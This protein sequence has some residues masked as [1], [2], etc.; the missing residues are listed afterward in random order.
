MPSEKQHFD[1]FG[2]NAILIYISF[3]KFILLLLFAGHYGLFRDEYYY[4]ECSK[5]LSWG[6][7]DQPPLSILILAFSRM[8]FGDSILGIRLFAYIASCIAI[9]MSGLIARQLGGGRFAQVLTSLSM[10]FCAVVLG[11]GSYFSMNAFDV[12]FGSIIF[13]LL[14]KL[15][16]YDNPKTWITLGL[17]FGIGLEN[18]F[19]PLFLAFGLV[20][21][22]FLTKQRKYFLTKELYIGAAIAFLIFLP[23]VI[24]Q[25]ANNF[26]TLEFIRNASLLKNVPLGFLG[27]LLGSLLELNPLYVLY[28]VIALIFLLFNK[29]GKKF[30]LVAWTYISVFVVFVLN[31]G[32]PYYMG[33]LYPVIIASGIVGLDILIAENGL[34]WFR[35]LMI[36]ILVASAVLVTPFSIPVLKVDSFIRY[37]ESL[38]LK[39]GNGERSSLGILPQFYADRFG[40]KEM[41]EK[42]SVVYNKLSDDEKKKVLIFAQNY[43]EA[44]AV[45]YYRNEFELPRAVSRHNSFWFWGYPKDFNGDIM[46]VIGSNLKD[47]SMFFEK[48]ELTAS[49]SS[50]YGM[51]YE[52]VDIFICRNLKMP[53]SELWSK[54][55]LFI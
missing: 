1:L 30:A 16:K 3:F 33:I 51:P 41:V 49:H 40:W 5:H 20:I 54:I 46:I 50:P 39:P 52:N 32:K 7:V 19:T 38:G 44:S 4:V 17:V 48:V 31:N 34:K 6:Y 9:F 29:S 45:N 27:F 8:L 35:Y 10:I 11:S 21:G 37:S 36:F 43:G 28:L 42:V 14:I 12:L 47:N 26:P 55:K 22:L 25:I 15:I 18:K 2:D 23:H 24:W 53:P 13:Y